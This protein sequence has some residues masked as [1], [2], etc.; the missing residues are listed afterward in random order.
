MAIEPDD[1][2]LAVAAAAW[3][4]SQT[5]YDA[6]KLVA[7]GRVILEHVYAVTPTR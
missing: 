6:L 2:A 4:A 5:K 1:E 3:T 7:G